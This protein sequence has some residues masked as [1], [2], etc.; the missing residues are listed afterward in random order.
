MTVNAESRHRRT[1][2]G[3]LIR[4]LTGTEREPDRYER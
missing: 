1:M 3:H 2:L 4:G